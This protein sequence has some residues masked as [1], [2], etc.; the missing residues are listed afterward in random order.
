MMDANNRHDAKSS[1]LTVRGMVRDRAIDSCHMA[2]FFNVC[3]IRPHDNCPALFYSL[4]FLS[5]KIASFLVGRLSSD[6]CDGFINCLF[7]S[8]RRNNNRGQTRN[9][10]SSTPRCANA[11]E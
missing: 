9:R 7:Y 4:T 2:G 1:V 10:L 3:T 11:P 5:V 6:A 8:L